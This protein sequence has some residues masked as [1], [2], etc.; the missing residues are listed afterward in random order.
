MPLKASFFFPYR[1]TFNI[2]LQWERQSHCDPLKQKSRNYFVG[3][4][5]PQ[6]SLSQLCWVDLLFKRPTCLEVLLVEVSLWKHA[7]QTVTIKPGSCIMW[8]GG[9]THTVLI[10]SLAETNVV[11]L[12]W[13]KIFLVSAKKNIFCFMG[14]ERGSTE[15]KSL[16]L[17][18]LHSHLLFA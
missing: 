18:V 15:F 9:F 3:C 2:C 6:C 17:R 1:T 11:R 16:P 13:M 8:L 7:S 14:C 4:V 12:R 5:L 10:V